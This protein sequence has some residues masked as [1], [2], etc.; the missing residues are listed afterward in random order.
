MGIDWSRKFTTGEPIYNKFIEWQ[1]AKLNELGILTQGKY[2]ILYSPEYE[3]AVGEDDIKD[4]DTE[5]VTIQEM[6]Y[7][8]FE[9]KK[10]KTN[11]SL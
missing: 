3:N 4:G 8:L 1:Y 6:T 11:S 10:T 2:P 9:S 5:K 7:I